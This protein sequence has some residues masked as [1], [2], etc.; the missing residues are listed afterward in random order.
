[1]GSKKLENRTNS[2]LTDSKIEIEDRKTEGI[3]TYS[4][5]QQNFKFKVNSWGVIIE[6]TLYELKCTIHDI[7]QQMGFYHTSKNPCVMMRVNHKT[8]S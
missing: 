6:F 3:I 8:K 2:L 5:E 4:T 1:M 7:L